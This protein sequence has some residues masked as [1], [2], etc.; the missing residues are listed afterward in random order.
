LSI[1]AL[2]NPSSGGARALASL[3]K[4]ENWLKRE[5]GHYVVSKS[6]AHFRE[7]IQ[8]LPSSITKL[9]IAGGDSSLRIAAYELCKAQKKQ[10]L[11]VLPLGSSD[12]IAR[13]LKVLN[14]EQAFKAIGQ[15][16]IS[17]GLCRIKSGKQETSYLGAA[18]FGL[19]SL[20]NQAVLKMKTENPFWQK[21]QFLAG[22]IA[23]FK[24]LNSM[25]LPA[26]AKINNRENSLFTNLL[27]TQI[28]YW[29]AGRPFAYE[30]RFDQEELHI[31]LMKPT[32][33]ISLASLLLRTNRE[34]YINSSLLDN[35]TEKK[36]TI[37]FENEQSVQL[38]G[39][40]WR[41][42]RSDE[43]ILSKKFELW[44]SPRALKLHSL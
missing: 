19:G 25:A 29:S 15:E 32:S 43:L 30:A 2:V 5:E 7:L 31:S 33:F 35:F 11:G 38:D 22:A 14:L 4:I 9:A 13:H 39:D 20:V 3:E 37:E 1:L 16:P 36:L 18:S 8:G 17:V 27:V 26:R 44:K 24:C 12:D 28:K 6:E 34:N 41:E 23:I 42:E 10:S 21:W 40:V